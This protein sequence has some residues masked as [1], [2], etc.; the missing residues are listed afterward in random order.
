MKR[1]LAFIFALAIALPSF[2]AEEQTY[3]PQKWPQQ[4]MTGTFDRAALQRGFQVYKQI[5]SA[6]HA[7][8]QLSYRDLSALGYT[9]GQV[10]AL[11]ADVTVQ[12]GPDDNGAMFDR[13]GKPSDHFKSPFPNEKAARAANGGAYPKDLSLMIKAREGH[14]DYVYALLTGYT[15]PPPGVTVPAGL[16]YNQAFPGH[17]I[18]MPP[19]LSADGLVTYADGTVATKAQMARDVVQ[20]L[21]WAAEPELE[22][23]KKMGLQVLIFLGVFTIVMW[24]VK[25]QIWEGIKH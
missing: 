5:C 13:P 8:K 23:R 7:M 18:G 15:D 20:F 17:M 9:D 24:F 19:P 22:E 1:I 11:A 25:K 6:C 2:A 14:A 16:Y 21:S 12:D 10:K 4:G 3:A